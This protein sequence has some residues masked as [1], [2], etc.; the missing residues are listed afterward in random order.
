MI[1]IQDLTL[2]FGPKKVLQ[3]FSLTLPLQG[4]TAFSGPSGCG[5]TTLLRC[6][7]GLAQPQFGTIRGI[8]AKETAFLFQDNRLLPWRTVR[9]QLTDVLPRERWEEAD[10][11]LELAELTGEGS[12]YPSQL[13]GGM[14]RRLS[15]ARTLALDSQLYLLDEPFAGVDPDRVQRIVA[16]IREQGKPVIL[17]SH[18][19]YVLSLA[20]R[21]IRMDGPPL[22]L[23]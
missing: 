9:Q 15:L 1:E 2:S 20:D 17:T 21:V 12:N 4:I 8:Q 18:L 23:L 13:S 11:Y 6:L 14:S 10:R 3:H 22:S 19:D 7:A 16:A 5:K